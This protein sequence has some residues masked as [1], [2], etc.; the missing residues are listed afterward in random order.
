MGNP[1]LRQQVSSRFWMVRVAMESAMES[2]SEIEK[3]WRSL[4]M[5]S[6][7]FKPIVLW[8][9]LTHFLSF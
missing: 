3:G 5:W 6:Q 2:A 1:G 9:E 7:H 8:P 4:S